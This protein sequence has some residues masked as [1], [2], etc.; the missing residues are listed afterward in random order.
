MVPYE[1]LEASVI[2]H[3]EHLSVDILREIAEREQAR[4]LEESA[5]AVAERARLMAERDGLQRELERLAVTAGGQLPALLATMT[6]KQAR[7]DDLARLFP[8]QLTVI[9]D[10][11]PTTGKCVGWNYKGDA[12]LGALLGHVPTSAKRVA[13]YLALG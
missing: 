9:P 10:V 1:A 8:T 5:G 2:G 3:F 12:M 13:V 7:V 4:L 11:D 6:A